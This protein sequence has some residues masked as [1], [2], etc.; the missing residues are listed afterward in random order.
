MLVH[1]ISNQS[2]ANALSDKLSATMFTRYYSSLEKS[3]IPIGI[4]DLHHESKTKD[5]VMSGEADSDVLQPYSS[6]LVILP[7]MLKADFVFEELF[8]SDAKIKSSESGLL[9]TASLI[10]ESLAD[11]FGACSLNRMILLRKRAQNHVNV[12]INVN[13]KRNSLDLKNL[14]I[15]DLNAEISFLK[16]LTILDLSHNNITHIPEAFNSLSSLN[17]LDLANNDLRGLPMLGNL[18]ELIHLDLSHNRICHLPNWMEDLRN[19]EFL[20]ITDNA[21]EMLPENLGLLDRL[22][23][24]KA[25]N[26]KVR[27]IPGTLSNNSRLFIGL[28][29]NPL[30][31]EEEPLIRQR[32]IPPSLFETSLSHLGGIMHISEINKSSKIVSSKARIC[33]FCSFPLIK[34]KLHNIRFIVR[35]GKRYPYRFD[36]CAR[37][38]WNNE[39]ERIRAL[40]R[41]DAMVKNQPRAQMT[42]P[43]PL[44]D[45]MS[46]KEHKPPLY[47]RLEPAL[48]DKMSSLI[49]GRKGETIIVC[50]NWSNMAHFISNP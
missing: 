31:K 13:N 35:N 14:K 29:G 1:Y 19:L 39:Q 49:S 3:P 22:Q 25:D 27:Y 32:F 36:T 24:I 21:I 7:S 12:F 30:V 40:F 9:S 17:K 16:H 20:L 10:S 26:N 2:L 5:M 41:S 4:S 23:E 15:V 28:S 37:H 47:L 38:F 34:S 8:Q 46:Y 33:F 44:Y 42:M 48:D 11:L 18:R 50:K 6:D 43:R 45:T